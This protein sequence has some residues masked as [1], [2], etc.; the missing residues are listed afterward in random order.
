MT[1][2]DLYDWLMAH[3]CEI[4]ILV[5]QNVTGNAV[6]VKKKNSN[7]KAYINTPIDDTIVSKKAV[8]IVC[9]LLLVPYPHY[10]LDI[11]V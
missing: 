2:Q 10:V 11:V 6:R 1:R 9:D 5:G 8:K 4:E 7:L 3:D